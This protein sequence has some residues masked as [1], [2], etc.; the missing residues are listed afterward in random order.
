MTSITAI[1]APNT[2]LAIA[3]A[4]GNIEIPSA[5]Q[6]DYHRGGTRAQLHLTLDGRNPF[7][8]INNALIADQPPYTSS[9]GINSWLTL[10]PA[11]VRDQFRL[12]NLTVN[13]QIFDPEFNSDRSLVND[14]SNLMR[15]ICYVD[16]INRI[17]AK[18][19]FLSR[20]SGNNESPTNDFHTMDSD[21]MGVPVKNSGTNQCNGYPLS[22]TWDF[23]RGAEFS[24]SHV[25]IRPT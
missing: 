19:F 1:Q 13:N 20:I 7:Q 23:I 21:I 11:S 6:I 4:E 24:S 3:D 2:I 22:Y 17:D 16:F 18:S 25:V 10:K 15:Y 5:Q 14:I 12:V 9:L 8:R